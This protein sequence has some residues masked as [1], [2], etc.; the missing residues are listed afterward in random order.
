MASEQARAAYR[1]SEVNGDIPR[2]EQTARKD[3]RH[4]GD[5]GRKQEPHDIEHAG[6]AER[7]HSASLRASH[8]LSEPRK[9]PNAIAMVSAAMNRFDHPRW[10]TTCRR[11]LRLP[12]SDVSGR[13]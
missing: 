1:T 4:V 11:S 10:V 8:R 12:W 5:P 2:W 13:D 9:H 3:G 7:H 6:N